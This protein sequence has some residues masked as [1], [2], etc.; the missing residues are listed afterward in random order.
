[1]LTK[2]QHN[3]DSA[4]LETIDVINQVK[5]IAWIKRG[6]TQ[7]APYFYVSPIRRLLQKTNIQYMLMYGHMFFFLLNPIATWQAVRHSNAA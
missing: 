5:S 7:V 6:A 4:Y 3:I 2:H 1:V